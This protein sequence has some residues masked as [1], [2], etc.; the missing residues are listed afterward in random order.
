MGLGQI[1]GPD[2]K[3]EGPV[4]RIG[5]KNLTN[6]AIPVYADQFCPTDILAVPWENYGAVSTSRAISCVAC[7]S[8]II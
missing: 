6:P 1:V 3:P 5:K 8:K 4:R 2:G 7:S